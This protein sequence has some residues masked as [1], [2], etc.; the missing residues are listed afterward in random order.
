M[1]EERFQRFSPAELLFL[2]IAAAY[3]IF[4]DNAFAG[5]V[6]SLLFF[7]KTKTGFPIGIAPKAQRFRCRL[8]CVQIAEP[9]LRLLRLFFVLQI[10]HTE[11]IRAFR[12]SAFHSLCHKGEQGSFVTEPHLAFR[13]VHIDID[14]FR[15]KLQ[16]QQ[17]LRIITA[18]DF[19]GIR[20]TD[21]FE[22]EFVIHRSAVDV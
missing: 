21:G 1:G 4:C 11:I 2:L 19:T 14:F 5:T 17:T 10:F 16:K 15:V 9:C 18:D 3:E 8:L 6:V 22:H 7:H 12:Q 13:R 20:L